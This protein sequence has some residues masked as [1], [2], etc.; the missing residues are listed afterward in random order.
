MSVRVDPVRLG[1]DPRSLGE[2]QALAFDVRVEGVMREAFVVRWMGGLHAYLNTC[3]HQGLRLDFGD[4]HFFDD[5]TTRSC[6][7]RRALSTGDRYFSTD[8]GRARTP[9]QERAGRTWCVRADAA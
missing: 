1:G 9:G 4:L 7:H 5:S 8:R 6:R 2:G 3:R